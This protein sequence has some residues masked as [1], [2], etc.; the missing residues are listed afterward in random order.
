M[1]FESLFYISGSIFF[2][3]VI[4]MFIIGI[5]GNIRDELRIDED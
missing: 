2:I 5:I 4:S 1:I 3:S